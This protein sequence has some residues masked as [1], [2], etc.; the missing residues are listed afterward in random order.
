M[1][2]VRRDHER[3][4]KNLV[5]LQRLYTAKAL[6]ICIGVNVTTWGRKMKEPWRAFSYDDLRMISAYCDIPLEKLI[7]GEVGVK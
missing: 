3:L 2:D 6:A 5:F 1:K 7:C 4:I